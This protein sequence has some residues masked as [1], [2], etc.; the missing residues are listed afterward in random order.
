MKPPGRFLSRK[1]EDEVEGNSEKK[2][3]HAVWYDVGDKKA[4]LKTS[5]AL[6]ERTPEA[7]Q[8]LQEIRKQEHE[9]TQRTTM[10][11][12]QQLGMEG[13]QLHAE[14]NF[15]GSQSSHGLAHNY[16]E[17]A[18]RASFAGFSHHRRD[19][20]MHYHQPPFHHPHLPSMHHHHAAHTGGSGG[21]APHFTARRSS[22]MGERQ[23][24]LYMM[25]Q[26][27]QAQ[28][29]RIDME[30][31]SS[32]IMSGPYHLPSIPDQTESDHSVDET[33]VAQV[34]PPQNV[35]PSQN[36]S[37]K[38]ITNV[39]ISQN[40][41]R[42]VSLE[43]PFESM[44]QSSHTA[45]SEDCYTTSDLDPVPTD[46]FDDA[47]DVVAVENYR[48]LLQGWAESEKKTTSSCCSGAFSDV[49]EDMDSVVKS[50][51]R[52]SVGRSLSGCSVHSTLSELMA[53]SIISTGTEDDFTGFERPVLP[54]M[55]YFD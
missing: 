30:M 14:P 13:H 41:T 5:M 35:V 12:K 40:P 39:N 54:D 10:Y 20:G 1:D 36:A 31:R 46:E 44:N 53:M 47:E 42:C 51:R 21:M 17:A 32:S 43:A 38:V 37:S 26:Q 48:T 24:Q 33:K 28:Q 23:A 2:D 29:R 52:R 6:R 16:N 25:Q 9:E 4:R 7:V 55:V 45:Q 11:V 50:P 18:R 49:E 22:L 27:V 8:Y 15:S 34:L 3:E 19:T